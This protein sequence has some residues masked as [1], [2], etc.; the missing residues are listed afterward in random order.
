MIDDSPQ[1]LLF[2]VVGAFVTGWIVAKIGAYFGNRG[3]SSQRDPKEARIRSLE[4]E[5]RVAR[6][7][8]S[9]L[10]ATMEERD[11]ELKAAA[12]TIDEYAK[13]INDQEAQVEKLKTNLR[14]SVKKTHQLRDELSDRAE[15]NLRSTVKLMQVE[16]ELSVI[17]ET[18][19]LLET[20]KMTVDMALEEMDDG[21]NIVKLKT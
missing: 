1:V 20:G 3:S 2:A 16:T 13:R 12:A 4:A 18:A 10:E 19:S 7:S 9:K 17:Q 6:S 11:K 15:E 21:H 5:L 8:T 14:D